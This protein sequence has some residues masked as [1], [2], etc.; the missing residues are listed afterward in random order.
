MNM[1][2]IFTFL[3]RLDQHNNKKWMDEYRVYYE[4]SRHIFKELIQIMLDN[5]G[6][7]DS[8]VADQRVQDSLFYLN[9][10]LRFNKNLPPYKNYFSA[11]ISK[12]GRHSVYSGYYIH[13]QPGNKSFIGAGIY[14]PNPEILKTIRLGI[15][16]EG[17]RLK[18]IMDQPHF[19]RVFGS[20]EG[21]CLKRAPKE[22][23]ED[24]PF[25]ELIKHKDF[26]VSR[27]FKDHEVLGKN[28]ISNL[29]QYC[30]YL[31]NFNHFFNNIILEPV[32][33]KELV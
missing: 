8:Q 12:E 4:E 30:Y 21:S 32:S 33:D 26:I 6:L 19:S 15:S 5:V 13:L 20:M 1:N 24:H 17:S 2:K 22:F 28:F 11:L 23:N 29:I 7:F 27:E 14:H 9:R 10:N 16:N 18:E 31:K 3:D 25:I